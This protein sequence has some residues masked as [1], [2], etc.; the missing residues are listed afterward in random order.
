M[1]ENN[2]DNFINGSG[3][4]DYLFLQELKP[5]D[6]KKIVNWGKSPK[7]IDWT[8]LDG[9]LAALHHDKWG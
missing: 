7:E 4:S 1:D 9:S 5:E 2:I 3:S 8:D 6:K